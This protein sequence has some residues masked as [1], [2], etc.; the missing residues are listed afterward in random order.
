MKARLDALAAMCRPLQAWHG[1]ATWIPVFDPADGWEETAYEAMSILNFFRGI[2]LEQHCA[3][4]DRRMTAQW[5]ANVLRMVTPYMWLC[6]T[7]VRQL[8]LVALREVAAVVDINGSCKIEK[9]AGCAMED[10]ELALLP[11]L[12]IESARITVKAS[13]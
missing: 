3:L 12:P 8:D 2:L 1:A 13:T 5:C 7:L 11:V 6:D 4:T 10:F 9:L